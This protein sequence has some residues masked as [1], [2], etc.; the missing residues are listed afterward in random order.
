VVKRKRFKN[1]DTCPYCDK[2]IPKK[3]LAHHEKVCLVRKGIKKAGYENIS[4][5]HGESIEDFLE[6]IRSM[7][8]IV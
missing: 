7:D 3:Y 8:K 2:I 4:A 6:R 5:K 1:W